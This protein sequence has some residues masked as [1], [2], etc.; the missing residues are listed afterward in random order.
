MDEVV[1]LTM[2]EFGRTVKENWNRGTDRGHAN[3]MFMVGNS[4]RG[5]KVYG[6]YSFF[7]ILSSLIPKKVR[8]MNGLSRY[9]RVP[10]SS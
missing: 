9:A 7:L 8:L 10:R 6:D 3:A 2:S 1:L 5:G 4:V